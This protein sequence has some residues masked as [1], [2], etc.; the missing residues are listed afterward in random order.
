[1]ATKPSIIISA[2]ADEAAN[3]R[4]ALEQIPASLKFLPSPTLSSHDS[5]DA[6]QPAMESDSSVFCLNV[7]GDEDAGQVRHNMLCGFSNSERSNRLTTASSP[8]RFALNLRLCAAIR[9]LNG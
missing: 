2:F 6:C 3:H 9:A 8:D 5:P 7:I 4:T 1:M